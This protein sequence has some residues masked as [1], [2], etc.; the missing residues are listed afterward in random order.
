[1]LSASGRQRKLVTTR[2]VLDEEA[3]MLKAVEDARG[4]YEQLGRAR[5][6]SFLS[7]AVTPS[8]E[9]KAAVAHV[10]R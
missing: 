10:L 7:P 3:A 8:E 4:K 5:E 1:V 9:P 2:E 6:W